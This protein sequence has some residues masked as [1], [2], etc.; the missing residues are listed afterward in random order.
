M[1]NEKRLK[2]AIYLCFNSF[3]V[4]F[5]VRQAVKVRK[6]LSLTLQMKAESAYFCT[7]VMGVLWQRAECSWCAACSCLLLS[8][9]YTFKEHMA[10]FS[11]GTRALW[12]R[13]LTDDTRHLPVWRPA[14]T[15]APVYR[16]KWCDLQCLTASDEKISNIKSVLD[17]FFKLWLL[18]Y[19]LKG[20]QLFDC[21]FLFCFFLSS[22]C[23]SYSLCL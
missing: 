8:K 14:F 6:G 15:P 7:P 13:S 17:T 1:R 21:F 9:W 19:D 12:P 3:T 16:L 4:G 2:N 18:S 11:A 20:G 10:A 22:F 5:T 23:H